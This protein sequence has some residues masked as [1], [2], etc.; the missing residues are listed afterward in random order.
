MNIVNPTDAPR[1]SKCGR[2]TGHSLWQSHY[3]E[4]ALPG[5]GDLDISDRSHAEQTNGKESEKVIGCNKSGVDIDR[6][7]TNTIPAPSDRVPR[8]AVKGDPESFL[9]I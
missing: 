9:T 7:R 3:T 6:A 5:Q 8:G 4:K 1:E 2:L